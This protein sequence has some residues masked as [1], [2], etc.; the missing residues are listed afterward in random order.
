MA[1]KAEENKNAEDMSDLS[2]EEKFAALDDMIQKLE[3]ADISLD[4]SFQ[5]YSKGMALVNEC[6]KEIEDVEGKVMKLNDNGSLTEFE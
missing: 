4:Q 3:Q 5:L 1:K 2:L 6:H